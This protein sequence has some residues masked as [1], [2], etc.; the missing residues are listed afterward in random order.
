[1][2]KRRSPQLRKLGKNSLTCLRLGLTIGDPA[3]I[4]P[5]IL[6]KSLARH[7]KIPRARYLVFGPEKLIQDEMEAL[8]L[9]IN[10]FPFTH[11]ASSFQPGFYLFPFEEKVGQIKKGVPSPESGRISFLAFAQ[12]VDM[13]K[14]GQ[15]EAIITA[16]ISKHSWSLI[17]LPWRG[18]TEYL[19]QAYPQAI[20]AF[21]SSK[22]KVVLL[23]H[24]LSLKQALEKIKKE[25]LLDFFIRLEASVKKFFKS[26][27]EFLVAGLNPHAGENG[28]LGEEEKKEISPAIV[29]AQKRGINISGPYP[30]DVIF[31][32]ALNRRDC[33][34]IA[35]Y[36]DQGLIPFK[37]LS[38]EEGVNVTLGLPFI[39]TSPD[40]GTA[41]D[42]APQ[43]IASEKSFLAAINLAYKLAKSSMS[44][45]FHFGS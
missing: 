32:Q 33:L 9:K 7:Q 43:R 11:W 27:V 45:S 17:G 20:M 39:R 37:L 12:A 41:F 34:V 15:L 8:G 36:H 25:Y 21:W 3:G 31:R 4:G 40:H 29:E 30:P 38:F 13:A 6:L 42:I 44:P 19:E 35:L 28:L 1:M 24:H 2:I 22:L 10:F 23:S 26:K 5:E 16:P 18:H 14:K